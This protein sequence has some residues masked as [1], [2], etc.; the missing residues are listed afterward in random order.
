MYFT[1]VYQQIKSDV[2]CFDSGS[3]MV[4]YFDPSFFVSVTHATFH[5]DVSIRDRCFDSLTLN[6]R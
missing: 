4:T 5:T 3:N 2:F 1:E 6:R